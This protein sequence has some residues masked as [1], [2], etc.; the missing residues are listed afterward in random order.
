MI[1]HNLKEKL[2]ISFYGESLYHKRMIW[3]KSR[4][5]ALPEGIKVLDAG[6]GQCKNKQFLKH[7]QYV[8]QDFCQYEGIAVSE[9]ENALSTPSDISDTGIWDTSHIDIVSDIVNI[10]VEAESFGAVVCTEV[11]EHIVSPE[12]A[13]KEFSRIMYRGGRLIITAPASTGVHMAPYFYYAG[14]SEF[15]YKEIL[16]KYGFE[17]KELVKNGNTF[18]KVK[19]LN[20]SLDVFVRFYGKSQK[21]H[22]NFF[23]RM[24][25]HI[26]ALVCEKYSRKTV[27]SENFYT[28]EILLIAEKK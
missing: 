26:A 8:A 11:F 19:E 18:D 21:M 25:M 22:L 13:I 6:A 14:L 15:W 17:I 1:G 3:T 10:P 9:K 27:G 4:L 23:E 20:N 2:Y 7:V 12:L 16:K 24:I 5:E 28:N